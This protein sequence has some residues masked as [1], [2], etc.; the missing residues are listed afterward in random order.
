VHDATLGKFRFVRGPIF[1]E[2]VLADEVNRAPAKT[3]S[4][5]LEAMEERQV[6]A[7]GETHALPAAFSLF[8]TM[9][10]IEFEGTYPLP[11]AQLDRFLFKID[12]GELD[13]ES[14]LAILDHHARGKESWDLVGSGVTAVLD[15]KSL[16]ALR[17]RVMQVAVQPVV[18]QYLLQLV[19]ASR[20]HPSVTWG[21][22][23]R[24]AVN[25]L[26][27]ARGRAACAGRDFVIPDDVKFVAPFCLAHRLVLEPDAQMSGVTGSEVVASLLAE[28]P[29]PRA[30]TA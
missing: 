29:V 16:V 26:R 17:Q 5:M 12:V 28:T 13:A 27:A 24:A 20:R 8:A 1:S 21:A 11:E 18:Q 30:E 6:T 14:E 4:A 25:L 23:T 22:S 19:R 9:N 10:P 2:V 3:Q 15:P 7:D